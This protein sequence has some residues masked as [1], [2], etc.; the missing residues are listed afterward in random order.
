METRET[1]RAVL[2][3]SADRLLM[4]RLVDSEG[5]PRWTCPGGGL[6][7]GEGLDEAVRRELWEETGLV[8]VQVGPLVWVGTPWITHR[9]GYA[10]LVKQSYVLVRTI[11]TQVDHRSL[12]DHERK[13][14]K[15]YRWWSLSELKATPERL[16]P[17]DD[18]V[19]QLESILE[20][21]PP[22]KP[23]TVSG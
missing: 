7:E 18:L 15:G 4:F 21:G 14:I 1:V 17:D 2:L 10:Q 12:Q 20:C 11:S 3:D 23:V 13:S 8:A 16:L 5:V 19:P 6:K 22:P 9:R